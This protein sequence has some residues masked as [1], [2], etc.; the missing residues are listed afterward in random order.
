MLLIRW[1]KINQFII[2]QSFSW[3]A[4]NFYIAHIIIISKM[5]DHIKIH[6]SFYLAPVFKSF[7]EY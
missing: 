5:P 3:I 6:T 1:T 7:H 2:N 4:K